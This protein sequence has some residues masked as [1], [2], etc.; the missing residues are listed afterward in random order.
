MLHVDDSAAL[1]P[2]RALSRLTGAGVLL[3]DA[4]GSLQFATDT[5]CE[6]LSCADEAQ[7]RARWRE[8]RPLVSPDTLRLSPREPV[9]ADV[10]VEARALHVESLG[11]DESAGGDR[12]IVLRD[13]RKLDCLET[14]LI[15]A[16]RMRSMVHE[17]RLLAHDLRAPLNAAHLSLELLEAELSEETPG[18]PDAARDAP[19]GWQRH[20]SIIR[21]EL[22]RLHRSL[23]A[24]LER[25]E[26]IE[27]GCSVIDLRAVV[28]EVARLL[29]PQA[30]KQQV[31]IAVALGE[32]PALV[33]GAPQLLRQA[34]L[35]IA[36]NALEALSGG[37]RLAMAVREPGKDVRAT[38]EDSGPGLS[39]EAIKEMYQRELSTCK[40]GTALYVARRIIETY[41]GDVV[42][43]AA[44]GEGTRFTLT[45]PSAAGMSR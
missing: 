12:V 16:S 32:A 27:P 11:T 20:V 42:V 39:K 4:T 13:R 45:F 23:Q 21:D 30:R 19:S 24:S 33:S 1:A 37:G 22:A 25:K 5:A 29:G 2:L 26:P 34:L 14:E 28:S 36:M 15:L 31:D 38:L 18:A 35:N 3:L 8:L 10:M 17:H 43:A 40:T 6:L 9:A 41:G 7:L 44:A